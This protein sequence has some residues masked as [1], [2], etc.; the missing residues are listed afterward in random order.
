MLVTL[1]STALHTNIPHEEGMQVS[2]EAFNTR[3][4][5]DPP[6]DDVVHL[7]ALILR[8]NVSLMEKI[9]YKTWNSNG[10]PDGFIVCQH[11]NGQIR[12]EPP[13]SG[14][15]LTYHLVEVH[16]QHICCLDTQRE[17]LDKIYG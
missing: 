12:E 6:M 13:T 16:R 2:R 9:T 1:H 5:L 17:K 15:I 14:N 3:D 11:L 4:A 10:H 7:I 8:S